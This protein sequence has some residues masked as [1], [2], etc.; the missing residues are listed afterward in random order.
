M[1]AAYEPLVVNHALKLSITFRD[2]RTAEFGSLREK[3]NDYHYKNL[4]ANEQGDLVDGNKSTHH[5]NRGRGIFFITL[6]SLGLLHIR[7]AKHRGTELY[8]AIATRIRECTVMSRRK[9]STF[10]TNSLNI[11][12]NNII[13]QFR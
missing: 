1:L 3:T 2:P 7:Q 13:F 10:I 5:K 9:H 4:G 12:S 6:E 11:H 8:N